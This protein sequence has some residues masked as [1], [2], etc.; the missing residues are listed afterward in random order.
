MNDRIYYSREAEIRAQRDRMIF[1]LIVT[2]FGVGI[3]AVI[4]LLF[5]PRAG[6]ETRRQIGDQLDHAS[7]QG[8]EVAGKIAKSVRENADKLQEE[9]KD[10]WQT[11][12]N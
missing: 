10:R 2:G 8:R 7:N 3:G 11:I 5:A 12:Q 1:A 9:V 6:D 4:A